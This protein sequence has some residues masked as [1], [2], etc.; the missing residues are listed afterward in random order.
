MQR[1]QFLTSAAAAAS[2]LARDAKAAALPNLL[3]VLA[4]QWRG[5]AFGFGTD[6]VIRTPNFDSLAK[7]GANWTRAYATNPVC[8]P[9]RSCILTGRYPHQT[10]MVHNGL[11]LPPTEVCWPE[12]FRSAGYKTHYIG[13]W[14]LDGPYKPGFVPQGGRRRGFQTF[15][16]FNG[17]HV[18][19]Q[20]WGYDND[21]HPLSY[22]TLGREEPYYEPAAQTDLA[23]KFMRENK[24]S[25]FACYL[26]WGPP[27]GPMQ[28]PRS[29]DLYEPGD[30]VLRENVPDERHRYAKSLLARYY[31]LCESLDHQMG[32]LL[33][34][35]YLEGLTANTLLIFT[36]DH[37]EMGGSHGRFHKG[38]PEDESLRVPLLMRLPGR[39][40]A[41]Y[42]AKTLIGTVD[43]M[44]T[45]L[46]LCGLSVPDTCVGRDLSAVAKKRLGSG[47]AVE[48][49]YC[50]GQIDHRRNAWRAIVTKRFKLIVGG[51]KGAIANR[52]FH[53]LDKDPFERRNVAGKANIR[54]HEQR[55]FAQLKEWAAK[56]GDPFPARPAAAKER[57]SGPWD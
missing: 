48:S 50:E 17:G 35:L 21:G 26:S 7:Q 27:H 14:H 15:E 16:G 28:P 10:G 30:I 39:I 47:N 53:N 36:S 11:Q 57:Y 4:D 13:K 44:P 54:R 55:L 42:E 40:P 52:R 20:H 24:D 56:T 38:H 43:L 46:S 23:M 34:F 9:N 8:S 12:S 32:R 19:H 33:R 6:Q 45:L 49:V 37:G 2:G 3:F 51:H 5:S 29:H 22:P 25:P 41:G 31:G 18:Y 1:R